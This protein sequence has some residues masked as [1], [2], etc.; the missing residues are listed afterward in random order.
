[1]T[2]L[3]TTLDDIR[4]AFEKKAPPE[5]VAI[6]HAA[7]EKLRASGL[8]ERTKRVGDAMP[9]F[10]LNDSEGDATRSDELLGSGPIVLSFF[11]GFW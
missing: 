9:S 3:Q 1:M 11:R 5:A 6:I 8:L 4:V 10:E 7:A 2:S